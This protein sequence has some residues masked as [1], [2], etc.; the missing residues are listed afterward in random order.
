MIARIVAPS[1]TFD[2]AAF[3][4]G[5]LLIEHAGWAPQVRED[6]FASEGDLAGDDARRLAELQDALNSGSVVFAARGG[7]GATRI[8]PQ[9]NLERWSA[10]VGFSDL[11]AIHA[12]YAQKGWRSVHGPNVT[13][14]G[15]WS[16][17]A[18]AELW[19]LLRG[20]IAAQCFAGEGGGSA[21]GCL[22]GGNLTVLAA[23]TGTPMVPPFSG[24]LV[25]LEDVGEKPYRLDRA[26]TQLMQGTDLCH[27]EGFVLGQFTDC[28]DGAMRVRARLSPLG[29]PILH[30]LPFGHEGDARAVVLGAQATLSQG[31]L[32][33]SGLFA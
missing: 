21:E 31:A 10:L 8:G 7:Y 25:L 33:C 22:V 14:L 9:L 4:S 17:E 26:I 24:R 23:L 3:E 16:G 18:R 15:S 6:I 19:G 32:E 20:E 2:R 13:T 1:S 5:L 29:V 12:L 28:H 11:T 27:A 30:G